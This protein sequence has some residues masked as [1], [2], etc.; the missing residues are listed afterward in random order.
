MRL[1]SS[2][3]LLVLGS[4]IL[5][6][7]PHTVLAVDPLS[8]ACKGDA[9]TSSVCKSSSKDPITGKD[10]VLNKATVIV[11]T[12]VGVASIIVIIIGG[13]KY[14]I[15]GGDSNQTKSAKDTVLYAVI[16]L[17]I[18]ATARLIAETVLSRL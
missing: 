18:A 1:L 12:I 15:S 5:L 2:L 17:V 13:F 8:E 10:G 11:S 6:A 7:V 9:S 3:L 16:G 4:L 14:V